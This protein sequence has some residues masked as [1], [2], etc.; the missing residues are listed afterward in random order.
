MQTTTNS[1]KIIATIIK[2]LSVFM[3]VISTIQ[4]NKGLLPTVQF[5]PQMQLLFQERFSKLQ[6]LQYEHTHIIV[7]FVATISRKSSLYSI[8]VF[9][10][11]KHCQQ[12][13][14]LWHYFMTLSQSF[15]RYTKVTKNFDLIRSFFKSEIE[16][17]KQS[18]VLT[19]YFKATEQQFRTSKSIV[20]Q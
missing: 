6:E 8:N 3:P 10:Q 18:P 1:I 2:I 5:L 14:L 12:H 9:K 11:P 15:L 19:R 7:H 4:K 13:L 17:D 16:G 20:L